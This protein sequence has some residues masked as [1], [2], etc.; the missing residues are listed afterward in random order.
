MTQGHDVLGFMT[1]LAGIAHTLIRIADPAT[2]PS[3][4]TLESMRPALS[5]KT[6]PL[7]AN[8]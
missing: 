6:W 2:V 3:V 5:G 8:A 7:I 1:G 4:L